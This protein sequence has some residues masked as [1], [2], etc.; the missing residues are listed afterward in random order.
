ME[1]KI[2]ILNLYAGIGGNRKE[3]D[4][5]KIEVTAVEINPDVANIYQ[6]FFPNDKVIV[7]DAHAYLLGHYKE[8]DFI[9]TSPP[10]PT[11]SR[12]QKCNIR[13]EIKY[14]DMKLY[15]EIILLQHWFKGKYVVENVIGYYDPLIRPQEASRHYFWSNFLIPTI[16]IKKLP[17]FIETS[18]EDLM[19]WLGIY[20]T[21]N[22]Y[23][24]SHDEK[25]VLR[26]CVHPKLGLHVFDCA[27]K[28]KQETLFL[29]DD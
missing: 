15:Q 3:W 11:H 28:S 5:D 13:A 24:G 7:G 29:G 22:I 6:D 8:Y 25:K 4:N 20:I 14:P 9:W 10:C 21:K 1:K 23:D 16:T 2:K 17:G 27:F 26:N 12:M 19:D 18:K